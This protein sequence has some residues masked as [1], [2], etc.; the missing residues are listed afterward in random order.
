MNK[1]EYFQKLRT[2]WQNAK[3]YYN[4]NKEKFAHVPENFSPINYWLVKNSMIS[5][6]LE[7]EPY[8]DAFT[9]KGWKEKGYKVKKGQKAFTHA[10]TWIKPDDDDNYMFPKTYALFH[11][12][13]VEA[14]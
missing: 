5:Q 14:I 13:Q 7:G 2:D 3:R 9:F 4:A 1:K 10:I 8:L 11:K 12:S 6:E